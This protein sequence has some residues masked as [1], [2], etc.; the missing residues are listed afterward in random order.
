MGKD[1]FVEAMKRDTILGDESC[2]TEMN[3]SPL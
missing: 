2:S 3:Y 1:I